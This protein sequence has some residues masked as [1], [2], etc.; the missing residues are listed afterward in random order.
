M[1]SPEEISSKIIKV[2]RY[3]CEDMLAANNTFGFSFQSSIIL[4]HMIV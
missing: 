4:P 1:K 3:D 2:N